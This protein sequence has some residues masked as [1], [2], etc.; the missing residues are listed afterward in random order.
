M[1]F[2][3]LRKMIWKWYKGILITF[4]GFGFVAC[5][6]EIQLE[7]ESEN[8]IYFVDG[9]ITTDSVRQTVRFARTKSYLSDNQFSPITDA[10]VI[11]KD[12]SGQV[13]TFQY[14]PLIERYEST[15]LKPLPERWY[16]LTIYYQGDTITAR[17]KLPNYKSVDSLFFVY[18]DGNGVFDKGW[19]VSIIAQE[20]DTLGNY[21][22]FRFFRNDSLIKDRGND[23]LM[24]DR[25]I[26]GNPI[27]FTMPFVVYKGGDTATVQLSFLTRSTYKYWEAV[28]F[29]QFA[30][31]PYAPPPTTPPTNLKSQR[32]EVVGWF[33]AYGSVRITKVVPK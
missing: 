3:I 2:S 13:D 30:W 24:D 23:F 27:R 33:G 15:T 8:P 28:Q 4:I 32:L 14:N 25:F 7:I 5:T 18:E 12:D 6:E 17:D 21:Y 29:N 20:P 26:N 22:L 19:Y 31:D 9:R 10:I 1:E 11:V 16:T